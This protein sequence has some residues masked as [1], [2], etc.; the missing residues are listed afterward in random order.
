[1]GCPAKKV[2][3]SGHGSS[4]MINRDTAFKIVEEMAK[5]VKIPVSVK[6]RLGWADDSL[7][8]EFAMGLQNAGADLITVHGRTYQQAFTGKADF[9]GIYELKKHLS[10]PRDRQRRR[11]R[12]RRRGGEAPKPRRIHDRP[13]EFWKP[14]VLSPGKIPPDALRDIGRYGIARELLVERKGRKGALEARKH[15]VEYLHGFPGVK[16]YRTRLVSVENFE[17]IRAILADI[18][19]DSREFLSV[20]ARRL[21]H[22]EEI[23]RH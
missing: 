4:L 23:R 6:T 12:L 3:K 5:A 14:L 1:M 15:L 18:R 21:G 9:T 7:L 8:T 22:R 20:R 17:D 13:R 10:I 19:N 16:T 11:R 2:V